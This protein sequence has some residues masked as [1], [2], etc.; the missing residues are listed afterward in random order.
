MVSLA[1][2]V[3]ELKKVRTGSTGGEE[4]LAKG[5]EICLWLPGKKGW[6]KTKYC[7]KRSVVTSWLQ[8]AIRRGDWIRAAWA[9][10]ILGQNEPWYFWHRARIIAV[11][12]C[13]GSPEL[14]GLVYGMMREFEALTGYRMSKEDKRQLLKLVDLV[15]ASTGDAD[16]CDGLH[17]YVNNLTGFKGPVKNWDALRLIVAVSVLLARAKHDRS[18]DA[19]LDLITEIV[20]R[21]SD[22]R[23]DE[24]NEAV[25]WLEEL[26]RPPEYVFDMHVLGKAAR[27]SWVESSRTV[28]NTEEYEEF[29]GLWERLYRAVGAADDY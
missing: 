14:F 2:F 6:F 20:N 19:F 5:S 26:S 27:V 13:L 17:E 10:L 11:E 4:K 29:R 18:S 8:K 25:R 3:P 16:L 15:C 21:L 22:G 1:E 9:G 12:D 23:V 24:D 7:Y 28:N